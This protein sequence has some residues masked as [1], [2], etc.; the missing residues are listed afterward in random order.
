MDQQA[1]EL[2]FKFCGNAD[3]TYYD[4]KFIPTK[5][6][7]YRFWEVIEHH[8]YFDFVIGKIHKINLEKRYALVESCEVKTFITDIFAMYK[9][10][11]DGL[12]VY[13]VTEIPAKLPLHHED[14]EQTLK[15]SHYY[16]LLKE[17][18]SLSDTAFLIRFIIDKNGKAG[19]IKVF[20]RVN[21][22]NVFLNPPINEEIVDHHLYFDS[23]IANLPCFKPARFRGEAVN[24][25]KDKWIFFE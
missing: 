7:N 13:S 17:E 6:S 9:I 8:K 22:T 25:L 4:K 5:E 3:T 19:R 18:L 23:L 15:K 10:G 21:S 16:R 24:F 20:T 11:Q 2:Y 14:L 1:S 12:K